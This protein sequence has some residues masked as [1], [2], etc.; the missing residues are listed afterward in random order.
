MIMYQNRQ[1]FGF[2]DIL[3]FPPDAVS[4]IRG[5]MTYP[6]IRGTVKFYQRKYS[7]L[8]V[9]E[10]MGLPVPIGRCE[11][12]IFAF[13]LHE[14]SSCA[15]NGQEPFAETKGHYDPENCPHPYHAGD[16][17]PLFGVNGFAFSAFMTDR[18]RVRDIIGKTVVIH[19]GPDDFSTQPAGNAGEKIACGIVNGRRK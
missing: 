8:V 12:P 10:I 6:N 4:Y 14:G 13:H 7:T 2:A 5:G 19:A 16:M 3:R 11:K 15:L 18:F 17:P 1:S 9:A